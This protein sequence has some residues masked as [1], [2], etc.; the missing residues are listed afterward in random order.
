MIEGG[1]L[2]VLLGNG[3]TAGTIVAVIM[4]A[5]LELTGSRRRRLN[6]ALDSKAV[7]ALEEFLRTFAARARWDSASTERLTSAG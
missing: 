1:F 5:F 2:E 3:M 7:P 4:V 6:L